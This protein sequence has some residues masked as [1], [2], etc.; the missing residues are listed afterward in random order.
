MLRI[1]LMLHIIKIQLYGMGSTMF[2]IARLL[3][4]AKAGVKIDSDYRLA[5]MIGITHSAVSAY[6]VGKSLPNDKVIAQLC[7]FSGDDPHLVLAQI[8]AERASSDEA[9]HLWTTLI[10]R[11]SGGA[12][13]AILSVLFTIGLIALP[14]DNARAS[15]PQDQKTSFIDLL[16]IV[17]ITKLSVWAHVRLRWVSWRTVRVCVWLF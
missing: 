6:R 4:A 8:Q 17:S 13:T 10:K 2:L 16:Y 11:L 14:A 1:N 7:A 15:G 12:S 5:K 3:D 9:R